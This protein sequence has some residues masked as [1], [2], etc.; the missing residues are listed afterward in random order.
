MLADESNDELVTEIAQLTLVE[1]KRLISELNPGTSMDQI[2][3]ILSKAVMEG[4][5]TDEWSGYPGYQSLLKNGVYSP[6]QLLLCNSATQPDSSP[7]R[8][9]P[10]L[11][12][13]I[14]CLLSQLTNPSYVLD[15]ATKD[16]VLNELKQ[17]AGELKVEVCPYIKEAGYIQSKNVLV[18]A[19]EGIADI[20]IQFPFTGTLDIVMGALLDLCGF[21]RRGNSLIEKGL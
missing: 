10:F 12:G 13:T 14:G 20:W 17:D 5:G 9:Y 8:D 16:R 11:F 4:L 3:T 21:Y 2:I 19:A 18:Q 7:D 6:L 1:A 15:G